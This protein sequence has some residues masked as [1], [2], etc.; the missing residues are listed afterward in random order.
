MKPHTGQP[1]VMTGNDLFATIAKRKAVYEALSS[2]DKA[3]IDDWNRRAH[4]K[5]WDEIVKMGDN[6]ILKHLPKEDLPHE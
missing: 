4:G 3:E 5:R 6:P 2:E 1:V